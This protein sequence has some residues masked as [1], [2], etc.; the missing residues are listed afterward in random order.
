[1]LTFNGVGGEATGAPEGWSFVSWNC[2]PAGQVWY[3]DAVTDFGPGDS[4]YGEIATTDNG[5]SYTIV[6]SSATNTTTLTV[7]TSGLTFDWA[8]VTLEVN[9]KFELGFLS[10]N[11]QPI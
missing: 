3:S 10:T 4:L 8:D 6:S 11:N 9:S 2:C 1:V 5:E 7:D